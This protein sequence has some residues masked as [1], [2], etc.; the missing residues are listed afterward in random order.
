MKTK[1]GMKTKVWI[2]MENYG[3]GSV[4]PKFFATKEQAEAYA[5]AAPEYE[6]RFCDD[7]SSQE[8]EFDD[9]GVLLN[10]D[11]RSR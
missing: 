9:N 6:D 4:F 3:D 11:K 2:Y 10:I 5:D 7:V 1:V 8:L